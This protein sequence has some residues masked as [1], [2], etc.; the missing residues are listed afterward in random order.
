MKIKQMEELV[1]I[2]RK[3]I[4][5]YEEQ[6]LLNIS[7]A[8]NGY[9]EYSLADAERLKQIKLLRRLSVPIDT[10][11]Q[12]LNGTMSLSECLDRQLDFFEKEKKNLTHIQNFTLS[13]ME[14]QK[15]LQDLNLDEYLELVETMEKEGVSFM[16]TA[17]KD[18]HMKKRAGA[19]TG[20]L[21]M[22]ILMVL[23]FGFILWGHSMDPLPVPIL[24]LLLMVP[25]TVIIGIVVVLYNRLK[26]I[27]GGEEDEASKY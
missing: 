25:V 16:D 8:E 23:I 26:E 20:A 3:N 22:S 18:R 27:E 13:L 17:Q 9:R 15:N 10:I 7:R 6:G 19:V 24:A 12:V 4:R 1:G 2:T 11:R 21:I 5:F 14:I